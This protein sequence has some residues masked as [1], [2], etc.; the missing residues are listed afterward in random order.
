MNTLAEGSMNTS[1]ETS[2][3][4]PGFTSPLNTTCGPPELSTAAGGQGSFCP[5]R[6]NSA[7]ATRYPSSS[8]GA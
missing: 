3:W 2:S 8:E 5:S 1:F 6:V 4:R 7:S